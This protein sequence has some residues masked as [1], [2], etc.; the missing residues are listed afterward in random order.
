MWYSMVAALVLAG[1]NPVSAA[2]KSATAVTSAQESPAVENPSFSAEQ[3]AFFEKRIRP[4]LV[5]QC[6]SCHAVGAKSV[7]GGLLLDSRQGLLQGGDSGPAIVPGKPDESLL[8]EALRFESY[9]MPPSGKLSADVIADF[10]KWIRMGAADPRLPPAAAK[11]PTGPRMMDVETGRQFWAFKSP[12]QVTIPKVQHKEWPAAKASGDV[13]RFLL[14]A[15]EK[16]GLEPTRD[17]DRRTWIRR[18]Y[19]DLIGIPPTPQEVTAF[20]EDSSPSAVARVVDRL[21][22][23]PHFG[24]RWGRHWLDIVR[25]SDSNGLDQNYTFFE[26]WRYRD[27][28]IGAF[29][30]D[31]PY[32]R[33]LTE[34]LAG[35]LLPAR[36]QETRD[37]QVIA[38]GFLAIGP[39]VL[40]ERVKDK[41]V[42]DVVDEQI[43]VMGRAV[44]GLTVSCAR[45]HDHKFDP[46][47]TEDYY[48]LA[49]IF[50]ST[51]TISGEKVRFV[52]DWINRPL[53]GV[54]VSALEDHTQQK[55]RIAVLDRRMRKFRQER[56]SMEKELAA[57]TPASEES[58]LAY[59]AHLEGEGEGKGMRPTGTVPEAIAWFRNQ[60]ELIDCQIEIVRQQLQEEKAT[61]PPLPACA[62]AVRESDSAGNCQLCI[63]GNFQTLGPEVPRGFLT[64]CDAKDRA[65]VPS[66]EGSGRRE[67]AEWLTRPDHPL[68]AR[69][70]V[71]RVWMHLFGEGLVRSVDNFGVQG[72]KPSHPEL[73]D[74]L[75][76]SFVQQGW[77][78]KKLI[79]ML[80]LTHA[81]QL[82][83]QA[84]GDAQQK[85]D[86]ENR[87]LSRY[88]LR[89]LD[90]EV[91]RDSMLMAADSLDRTMGGTTVA[92]FPEQNG[93]GSA[94]S[95]SNRRSVYLPVIR[96]DMQTVFTVFDFADPSTVVGQRSATVIAPQAL[97][98]LNNPFVL[99]QARQISEV[100]AGE[101]VNDSGDSAEQGAWGPSVNSVYQRILG[102]APSA[103]ELTRATAFLESETVNQR[104]QAA[105]KS[106]SKSKEA[107]TAL[108]PL[109]MLCQA[110]LA[111]AEFRYVP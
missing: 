67:L 30:A 3:L 88:P 9:E 65:T 49:G 36:S 52:S 109:A 97:Y 101:H 69:V 15:M 2:E 82:S 63:R 40:A 94:G 57:K 79:R 43:D 46:I 14:A 21:L 98:L 107:E 17:V 106:P 12:H 7:M 27:Y 34:Q 25:Y 38:T 70:Y 53:G 110:L 50:K 91:L 111:S 58:L 76:T 23:S 102:R 77:S 44:L 42:M 100:V 22:A 29:N 84:E 74:Y 75:A 105:D 108:S 92:N 99:E 71:N 41:L 32:D 59:L 78:T 89:R 62:M 85:I 24:E 56:D 93:R 61:L 90:C 20:L 26:A 54:D 68:T 37:C 80:V 103:E 33:F 81:Y 45:C 16:A 104:T 11:A 13:D 83:T 47:P 60:I 39:K 8:M 10:E 87:L 73:L 6:Y 18:V 48:A 95:L 5:E 35:D 72:E 28:V 19:L 51:E 66:M 55:K 64:V 1:Q 4:V 86:P 96:N 31:K